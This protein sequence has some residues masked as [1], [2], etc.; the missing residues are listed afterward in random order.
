MSEE[1]KKIPGGATQGQ[2]P[3]DAG[4]SELGGVPLAPAIQGKL[5]SKLR[6]QYGVMLSE[7]LPV[8]FSDLLDQLARS[9]EKS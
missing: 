2:Q 8:K 6:E 5:G 3:D 1:N 9:E 4:R 7:P